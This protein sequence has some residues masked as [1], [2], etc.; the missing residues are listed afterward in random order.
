[1][2]VHTQTPPQKFF[3]VYQT[4]TVLVTM[5]DSQAKGKSMRKVLDM[6]ICGKNAVLSLIVISLLD[7]EH[8]LISG[9]L[10]NV[11]SYFML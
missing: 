10:K 9:S 4:F 8:G 2:F 5:Y 7:E 11:K 3:C 1:M 6:N